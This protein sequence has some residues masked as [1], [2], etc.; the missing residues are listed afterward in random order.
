LSNATKEKIREKAKSLGADLVGFANIKDY[1]SPRSPDPK[2]ILPGVKS[3]VVLGF[4]DCGGAIESGNSVIITEGK[5]EVMRVASHV[6]Y[7]LSRYIES[8]LGAKAVPVGADAFPIRM[9]V[10]TMGAV[11]EVSLRH[12]A[13][14]AGMGSLGKHNMLVCKEFGSRV[15][16]SALLTE[17]ELESDPPLE[18]EICTDCN[19]C[20]E[21]CPAGALGKEGL[22][23]ITKCFRHSQPY[24]LGGAMHYFTDMVKKTPEEQKQMLRDV[25]FWNLYQASMLGFYYQCAECVRVCPL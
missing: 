10:D 19:L 24:S 15:M 11:Q 1:N 12:A 17:L 14:A 18:N 3:I 2:S 8:G 20:V 21:A 16:L 4:R 25:H 6:N 7:F 5:I 13:L 22:T 9:S 23:D